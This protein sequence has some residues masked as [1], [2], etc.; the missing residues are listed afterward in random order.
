[1]SNHNNRSLPPA[2]AG[3]LEYTRRAFPDLEVFP[4]EEEE[5]RFQL[6]RCG[7][8]KGA[9]MTADELIVWLDG[10]REGILERFN[11]SGSNYSRGN[12]PNSLT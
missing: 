12:D 1:M 9:P 5:G 11:W 2:L 6:Y 8:P 4:D 10:F 3:E 7:F